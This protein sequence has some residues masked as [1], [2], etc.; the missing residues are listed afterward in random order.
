[1]PFRPAFT[2]AGILFR[3]WAPL[4]ESVSLQVE[5]A[6]PRPVHAVGRG[7]HPST[8]ADARV[9]ITYRLVLRS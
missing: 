3:L 8:V 1:M 2:E 7:W 5:G 6:A 4:P 9:G